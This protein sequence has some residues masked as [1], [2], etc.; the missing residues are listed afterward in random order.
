M[1]KL[2]KAAVNKDGE[3]VLPPEILAR[4]GLRPGET[5]WVEEDENQIRL[6]PPVSHLD[7]VYIEPTN[8]CNLTCRTC[9]RNGWDEPLGR[10]EAETYQRILTGIQSLPVLPTLFFG[11]YG[12]PLHHPGILEMLRQA[13]ALGG[14]VEMITNGILLEENVAQELI[15]IGLDMLWV[16]IDGASPESYADVRLGAA[17]PSVIDNLNRL[18]FRK[19]RTFKA[20]PAVGV[21]FVA[22]KRNIKDL[23]KVLEIGRWI[24]A[25]QF[26]I[27]N[28]L[29]HNASLRRE[30]LYEKAIYHHAATHEATFPRVNWPRMDTTPETLNALGET[31]NG[32]YR[33]SLA[34]LENFRTF[35]TCPF[36]EKNS[37]SIRWDG[38]VSPCLPLLHSHASYL[39]DHLRQSTAFTVG[40]LNTNTLIQIW[41]DPDYMALRERLREFDFSPCTV[42]NSCDMAEANQED[43]F[44]N[45]LP[46]CGGCLWAQGLIQ[47]P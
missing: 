24:G 9:M 12:E 29:A 14:R 1:K 15:D 31:L 43:C 47:C 46:A 35:D 4:S 8:L 21:A 17:L 40:S 30:V 26:S 38:A 11:G 28:V 6:H 22:M 18:H 39:D 42:C 13:K 7:R 36:L 41:N 19:R 2:I 44:G 33:T 3:L 34:A 27:S 32:Q 25:Q 37:T 5:F 45:E 23:S 16:S 10:M 20:H